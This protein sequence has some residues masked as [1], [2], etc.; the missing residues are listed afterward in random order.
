MMLGGLP[1]K[2]VS[3]ISVPGGAWEVLQVRASVSAAAIE[4]RP[5]AAALTHAWACVY[6]AVPPRLLIRAGLANPRRFPHREN[7]KYISIILE[8]TC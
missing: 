2:L 3:C 1:G 5:I 6:D 7:P 8:S 4:R